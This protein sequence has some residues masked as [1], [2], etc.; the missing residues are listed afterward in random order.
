MSQDQPEKNF[1]HTT[2]IAA[3]PNRGVTPKNVG[4]NFTPRSGL[5]KNMK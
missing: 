5:K 3:A 4:A 1:A 2:A